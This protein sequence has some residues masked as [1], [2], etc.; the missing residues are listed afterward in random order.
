MPWPA[1]GLQMMSRCTPHTAHCALRTAPCTL[2]TAHC[3]LH[4]AHCALHTAHA[5]SPRPSTDTSTPVAI[6][7]SVTSP[8]TVTHQVVALSKRLNLQIA[9]IEPVRTRRAWYR[10]FK[11]MDLHESGKI[12]FAELLEMVRS[13]LAISREEVADAALKQTWVALDSDGTGFITAGE[14]GLFMKKGEAALRS[15]RPQTTWREKV[16]ARRRL[17]VTALTASMSKE[18]STT[19]HVAAADRHAC[20]TVAMLFHSKLLKLFPQNPSWFKLFNQMD[21]HGTGRISFD[22]MAEMVRHELDIS[23]EQLSQE[24]LKGVWAALDDECSGFITCAEFG[25]FMR[26]GDPAVPSLPMFERRRIA[27]ARARALMET[28]AARLAER[29]LV[30]SKKVVD[31]YESEAAQLGRQLAALNARTPTSPRAPHMRPL[32]PNSARARPAS[33]RSLQDGG[34]HLTNPYKPGSGPDI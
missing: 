16:A 28:T 21:N 11:H 26:I 13:E 1:C 7:S 12:T 32:Q 3:A 15:L 8:S 25:K 24:S 5:L 2:R 27:S 30:D 20:I 22:E 4:T 9:R 23:A 34:V 10:F 19:A 31:R 17:E 6:G 33:P 14:F 29:Q 18:R